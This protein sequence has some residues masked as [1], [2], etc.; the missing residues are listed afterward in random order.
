MLFYYAGIGKWSNPQPLGGCRLVRS[1]VRI[2]L[3]AHLSLRKKAV[4]KKGNS[5]CELQIGFCTIVQKAVRILL[6]ASLFLK[7]KALGKEATLKRCKAL[8]EPFFKKESLGKEM[9][10]KWE[11]NG[12][13]MGK[14]WE[15]NGEE[16]G[17]KW[18]RNGEES[19]P[20]KT[21]G[22]RKFCQAKQGGNN[23]MECKKAQNMEQCP[24]TWPCKR[25]G[26]CCECVAHHRSHG[27]LPACLR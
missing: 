1:G 5:P 19:L 26:L 2:L 22:K 10:K 14:K 15:R 13:E 9:G 4:P 12:K 21:N 25:K 17:K 20:S 8:G 27:D 3:P 24:C 6:P 16:M 11:R 18:R 23:S 7:R